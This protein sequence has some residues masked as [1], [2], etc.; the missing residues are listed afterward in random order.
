MYVCSAVLSSTLLK[1]KLNIHG[2]IGCVLS[3]I[4]S[5]VIIVHAPEEGRI[6]SLYDIGSNMCSIGRNEMRVIGGNMCSMGR[7]DRRE[8]CSIGR[9]ERG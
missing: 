7:N 6:D 4:G 2:K 8:Q 3:I 9:N 5:T 1:E